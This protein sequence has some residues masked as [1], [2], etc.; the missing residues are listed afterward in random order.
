MNQE[1]SLVLAIGDRVEVIGRPSDTFPGKHGDIVHIDT[2]IKPGTQPGV[3]SLPPR[4]IE[5][6]YSVKLNTGE[7]VHHLTEQQLRKL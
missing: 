4:Q 1:V 5:P 2:G 7:V 6:R 3:S